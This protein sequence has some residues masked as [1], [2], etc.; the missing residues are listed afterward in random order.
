[1]T[2]KY[3]FKNKEANFGKPL[4]TQIKGGTHITFEIFLKKG[5]KYFALRRPR[6]IPGH[7]LPP[8]AKNN[9]QGLLYFCHNLIKYGE[10]VEA[11][12]KRIVKQQTGV[13]VKKFKTVYIESVVQNKDGQW[14]FIH[15][16]IAEI[17]KI[18]KTNSLVTEVVEFDKNNIPDEFGW[19]SKEDLEWFFNEFG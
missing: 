7:E 6:G 3:Y 19:W 9:P 15:H 16:V 8:K 18:P 12:I 13:S 4:K 1:M 2:F 14:A 5:N 10:S 11:C 17:N